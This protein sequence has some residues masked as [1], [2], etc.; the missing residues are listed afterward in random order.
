MIFDS[1]FNSFR[2]IIA[3]FKVVNGVIRTGDKV[4]FFNTGKEYDADEVGVLKMDMVPRKELRT[5]DVGYIISG[6]KT[7]KEVKVGDTITH[8]SRPCDKAIDGFEEVKP[9]VFAGVYPIEAEDYENLRASLEKLQLMMLHLLSS[10]NHHWH[11]ALASDADSWDCS[12]WKLFRNV[13]TVS[14]I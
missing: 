3:Y 4:K 6:I 14:L 12:I 13:W 9:M 1:V 10:R 7:S 11:W 5:G 8:I 2:G